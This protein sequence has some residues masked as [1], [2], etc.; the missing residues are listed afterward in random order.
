MTKVFI[1]ST[2][3]DL[4]AYRQ[5]ANEECNR[6]GLVPIDMK[7]FPATG[8]GATEGSKRKLNDADLY[9]G[10]FAYRYGHI[11]EGYDKS[12]TEIEFEYAGN[13]RRLERLC[14]LVHPDY[15]WPES[16]RDRDN[17]EKLEAFKNKIDRSVIRAMFTSVE[18]FQGKLRLALIEWKLGTLEGGTL[19]PPLSLNLLKPTTANRLTYRSRQT[20]FIGRAKEMSVLDDFLA[21]SSDFLWLVLYGPGGSGKSRLVQEFCVRAAT[22]WRAGFLLAGQGFD[23]W[24]AWTPSADTLIAVDYA[25]E[26]V[27]EIRALLQGLLHRQNDKTNRAVV[28]VLLLERKCDGGWLKEVM[29]SRSESYE[30]EQA[31]FPDSPLTLEAM[32]EEELWEAIQS[33]HET[34][35]VSPP[36]RAPLMARLR[37]LDPLGLPLY[38]ILTADALTAGRDIGGWDRERLMRDVLERERQGWVNMGITAP[39]ENLLALATMA[40]GLTEAVLQDPTL[41]IA[42]PAFEDFDRSLY[43]VMTGCDLEGE[44]LPPLKPDLLGEFFV[45]NHVKG[46]NERVT[47]RQAMDLCSAAWGIV[48]G[49]T[50]RNYFGVPGLTHISPSS[51]VVFLHRLIED[52]SDHPALRCFLYRPSEPSIDLQ[53]WGDLIV[54]GIRCYLSSKDF[55]NAKS[56]YEK[57][58]ALTPGELQ[59]LDAEAMVIKAAFS[60]LPH[61]FGKDVHADPGVLLGQIRELAYKEFAPSSVRLAFCKG[62]ADAMKLLIATGEKELVQELLDE[63]HKLLRAHLN[64]KELRIHYSSGLSV[65]VCSEAALE[66]REQVFER[67][68]A[69]CEEFRD[70]VMVYTALA[71]ASRALCTTYVSSDRLPDAQKMNHTIRGL[72]RLRSEQRL[73]QSSTTFDEEWDLRFE[74]VRGDLVA[75]ELDLAETDVLLIDQLVRAQRYREANQLLEEVNRLWQR[76]HP[77]DTRFARWWG[78]AI[79]K[80]AD[81]AAQEGHFEQIGK[82]LQTLCEFS[83]N[84]PG[85]V[86]F[87]GYRSIL[88][89]IGL[90]RAA[91]AKTFST[92]EEMLTSL[93]RFARQSPAEQQPVA[94]WAEGALAL[95]IAYQKCGQMEESMRAPRTAASALRSEAYRRRVEARGGAKSLDELFTWLDDIGATNG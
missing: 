61:T 30:I 6:L 90:K 92:A 24:A 53:Y 88:A 50:K 13:E 77:D 34:A 7:Y 5:V 16:A 12:V 9:V 52:F 84:F 4:D 76:K 17:Q 33:M 87:A 31:R 68:R 10:I 38:A 86:E 73:I 49:S 42:L 95:C 62:A 66:L 3:M 32:D 58:S 2:S 75:M 63:Q 93:E 57:L 67:L 59:E 29:G 78:W 20:P 81:A 14:F 74:E 27:D 80:H 48:G 18:D 1:S 43:S 91:D 64:E 46:R 83:D 40:G 85:N 26:R 19:Q 36:D 79:M 45:L 51:F 28:R 35:S 47:E 25:A 69:F 44:S 21:R 60:L 39:Y 8:K 55:E 89:L 72:V 23:D 15:P 56:L 11:E 37:E 82:A 94:D 41:R 71:Q 22:H 70:E 54:K 65:L